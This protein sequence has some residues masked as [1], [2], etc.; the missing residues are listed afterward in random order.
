[1]VADLVS[2]GEFAYELLKKLI[3]LCR[4]TTF[5]KA[6]A[7]QLR[8]SVDEFLPIIQEIKHSGVELP[9]NRRQQLE[10]LCEK[11]RNG[12]ELVHQAS[13]SR[14][15]N[16]YKNHQLSKKM[17]KLEKCLSRF[18][19]GPMQAHLLADV[20]HFR[21]ECAQRFDRIEGA[22]RRLVGDGWVEEAVRR[23]E[24]E[25]EYGGMQGTKSLKVGK[26]KVKD[27]LIWR[28]DFRVVGI[29]GIGGSGKTTLAREI[30]RD[31]QIR[32]HFN[33]RI[34]FETVSQSPNVK[35]LKLKIWEQITG[36]RGTNVN[37]LI[38]QWKIRFD[39]R[40]KE[41]TLVVLDDVWSLPELEELIFKI[42]GC[43]T[44]VV[45]RFR[46]TTVFDS[47]YDVELLGEEEALSIFSHSAFEQQSIPLTAEKKLVLQVVEE[48]K[49]LPLALKVIGASLRGQ[50]PLVWKSARNKLSQGEAISDS[51]ELKLLKRMAIS[52]D[53]LSTKVREC[54]LD[55]G[56]FPEDKKIP[57]DVLINMWVEIHDLDE[58]DAFAILIELSNKNLLTLVKDPQNRAGDI[59]SSYCELSVTQHDVLRDV[60]IHMSN[61]ESLNMRKRLVMPRRGDGLPR[62]WLRNKD[63]PFE[64]QIVSIH[65][66][67]MKESDWFE[68]SFPN[69]EVLM[70]HFSSSTYFLP[71]FIKIMPKLKALVIINYS[72]SSAT[73]HNLS[74]FTSLV[75]LTSIWLEK[76]TVP[77][78]PETTVPL[79]SLR[80]ISLVLCEVNDSLSGSVADIP[81]IFPRLSDLTMDHCIDLIKLPSTICKI[82]SLE[83]LSITN[84]HDLYE[85]PA[86]LGNLNSLQILRVYACPSLKKLPQA[87]CKLKGLKYLDIS[88][89]VDLRNLPEGMGQLISLEKIDMRECLQISYLPSSVASLRSLVRVICDE[90]ISFSWKEVEKAIP[91][92]RVQV[93]EVCHTLDWL[94]E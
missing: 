24:E 5:F 45:S 93:A 16:L 91:E 13:A 52:I 50:P 9:Q 92:L 69:A 27:M 21:A 17:E 62:D 40:I 2:A 11:L 60:A 78:L 31:Y 86:E 72:T 54:F 18:V 37:D 49:G 4:K 70:L 82:R 83:S 22:A 7:E 68:M 41:P 55:L 34:I 42:P 29:S 1:M 85:L 74:V 65:T 84:C 6:R 61:R 90:D 43:K 25:R 51:H 64:A 8:Q 57:L 79:R 46:F 35:H 67:E 80:K 77:P 10:E 23:I 47:I 75:N 66:G 89:C 48:C 44:L 20:N 3:E 36:N 87:I 58:E 53:C 76:I 12:L 39:Q 32:S 26:E 59:Y 30:C 14:S 19:K 56:S 81:L 88:Q 73:L 38:P 71:P 63:Q 15:W 28:E 33:N 94:V